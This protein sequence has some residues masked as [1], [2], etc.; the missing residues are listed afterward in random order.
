M[1]RRG[2]LALIVL[3]LGVTLLVAARIGWVNAHALPIER[4]QHE[5]GEAVPLDGAFFEY[6]SSEPTQDYVV[7]VRGATRMSYNDYVR[8]Y[9]LEG[10]KEREGM[11]AK[12]VISVELEVTNNGDERGAFDVFSAVMVAPSRANYLIEDYDLWALSEENIE[13]PQLMI[14][15]R[16]HTSY[17]THVPYAINTYGD[18]RYAKDVPAG[19]YQLL[20]SKCPITK[21]VRVTPSEAV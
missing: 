3:V 4:E 15:V 14:S 8:T 7:M 17:V 9:G 5:V 1:R 12:S 11:D 13:P 19:E 2:C 20:L 6:A 21:Y 18:G 10:A 16:P